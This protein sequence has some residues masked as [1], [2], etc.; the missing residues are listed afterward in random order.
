MK[1]AEMVHP[2]PPDVRAAISAF[3]NECQ[4]EA[5]AFAV[6]EALGAIRRTFPDLDISDSDLM[7]AI[8]SE[9]TTAGFDIEYDAA[10]TSE[11]LKRRSLERWDNEGGA[12]STGPQRGDSATAGQRH[13][14]S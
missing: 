4:K 5:Q 13:E 1:D 14:R 6:S 7:D 3:L 10:K 8:T 11:T 12:I 9:A 2:I